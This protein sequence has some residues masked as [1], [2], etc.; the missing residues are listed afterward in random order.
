[1]LDSD[2]LPAREALDDFSTLSET[3]TYSPTS[4][5]L[6][7]TGSGCWR[8]PLQFRRRAETRDAR[9]LIEQIGAKARTGVRV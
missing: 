9:E 8:T 1:M 2:G 6:T 5:D 7:I 4:Q 3:E